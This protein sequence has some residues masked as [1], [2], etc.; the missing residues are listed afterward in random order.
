METALRAAAATGGLVNPTLGAAIE[1]AGYDRGDVLLL[2]GSAPAGAPVPGCWQD[3]RVSS[4]M[5]TRPPGVELDLNGVVKALAVNDALELIVG[6]GFVSA[7]GD[8]ATRG[9]TLIELPGGGSTRLLSG[10]MATSGSDRR[11]WL[12][13]GELQHHLIDPR[14]GRPSDSRWSQVTVAGGSCHGADVAAKAAF[15]LGERGPAWLDERGLPGRFLA[16]GAI[17][18]NEA[19]RREGLPRGREE[20]RACS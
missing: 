12:R 10:G 3:V 4:S 17:H 6:H 7:G 20:T 16:A 13:G 11:R 19:W 2:S 14:S 9:P 18:C 1:A 5:L 8:V 15:L